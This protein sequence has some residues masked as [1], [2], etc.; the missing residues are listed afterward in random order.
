MKI[1]IK[2]CRSA[3][4]GLM[5]LCGCLLLCLLTCV[6]A[7]AQEENITG[8]GGEFY[9]YAEFSFAV[10]NDLEEMVV[11]ESLSEGNYSEGRYVAASMLFNESRVWVLLIYPCD[12]PEGDLD[13]VG[14]KSAVEEFNSGYNQTVYSSTPLNISDRTGIAGQ[15]GNQILIAYQPSVQTLS[16]VL[17]DVNVSEG[18]LEY[19]PQSLQITVNEGSSPLWPGYCPG[20]ETVETIETAEPQVAPAAAE[21]PQAEQAVQ[22]GSVVDPEQV[23][24]D[25]AAIREKMK[26]TFNIKM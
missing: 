13:A 1:T 17:M 3:S 21:T 15:F 24:A 16:M 26:S 8:I 25:V 23:E 10:P 14:L 9:D 18:F 19:F 5:I 2:P 7:S 12:P 11:A 4:R 6:A 20:D 22:T